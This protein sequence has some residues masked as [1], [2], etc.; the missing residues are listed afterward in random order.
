MSKEIKLNPPTPFSGDRRKL[1]DFLIETEMYLAINR[2]I[3]DSD[4]KKIIFTLSYMR[5]G[6]AGPWKQMYWTTNEAVLGT[7][8]WA[9]FKAALETAFKVTDKIGDAISKMAT[10]RQGSKTADEHVEDFKVWA[11][12]SKVTEDA[13]LI[14]W[15]MQGLPTSLREKIL[16][17]ETPPTTIK[18]WYEYATRF[19]NQWRRAKAISQRLKGGSEPKKLRLYKPTPPPYHDPNA[20]EVDRLTDKERDEHMKRGLCFR[21]HQS[22]HRANTCS[23]KSG[24]NQ[25]RSNPPKASTSTDAYTRIKAIYNELNEEEQ[26]KLTSTLEDSGF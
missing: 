9:T 7:T 23:T 18:G 16:G 10:E 12:T 15:F 17:A 26:K 13:P 2:D 20:M 25:T 1:D 21:C 8:S 11:A 6:T 5:E 14:E 24:T 4:R 19:D 22:G 3:Y